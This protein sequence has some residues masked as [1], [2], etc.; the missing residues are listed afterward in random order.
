MELSPTLNSEQR[1]DRISAHIPAH[2]PALRIQIRRLAIRLRALIRL[3]SKGGLSF[4]V[5]PVKSTR[6]IA[7]GEAKV[8]SNLVHRVHE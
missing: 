8:V 7:G 3:N 6:H 5:R 4:R 2:I 1:S